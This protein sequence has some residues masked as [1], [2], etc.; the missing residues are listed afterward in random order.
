MSIFYVNLW[1]NLRAECLY[2]TLF[3]FSYMNITFSAE[4]EYSYFSADIRL[5]I[6]LLVFLDYS[7]WRLFGVW[8]VL[9]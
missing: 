9:E 8:M 7:V 4:A 3:L 6:Y 5:K 1:S 2:Y